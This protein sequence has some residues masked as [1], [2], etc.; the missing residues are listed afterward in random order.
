LLDLSRARHGTTV[1]AARG[2]TGAGFLEVIIGPIAG[3][4]HPDG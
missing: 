2:E 1:G 3:R 4:H